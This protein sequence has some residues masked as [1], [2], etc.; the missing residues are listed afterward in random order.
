MTKERKLDEDT[1][2]K[3]CCSLILSVKPIYAD[4]ILNKQK[5][6]ELRKQFANN[7]SNET[8]IYIYSTSPIKAIVG[9]TYIQQLWT[10][11]IKD[12]WNKFEEKAF[13][14]KEQFDKYFLGKSYGTALVLGNVKTFSKVIPL[15]IL[16]K[17]FAFTPPQSFQYTKKPLC[18]L[19]QK[20]P[21]E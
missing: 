11:S 19:L 1:I 16:R 7:T 18:K 14:S 2:S 20:L 9:F 15:E 21:F 5:T 13:I 3:N 6:V 4:A 12:I 10:L 17:K 8:R